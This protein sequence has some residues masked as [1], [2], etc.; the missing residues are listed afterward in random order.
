MP[1]KVSYKLKLTDVASRR[2]LRK[3]TS[4]EKN[5][6]KDEIGEL[7]LDLV[8]EKTSKQVSSVSGRAW[9]PLDPK[10]RYFKEK[11]KV[12]PSV[13]NLELTGAMLDSLET[14]NYRDGVEI[15][16]FGGGSD[17]NVLKAD[18]HNKFSAKARGTNLPKRQFIPLKNQSFSKD[19]M[20]DLKQAAA[21]YIEETTD[22]D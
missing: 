20:K 5:E 16:I 2:E 22:E 21:S 12:A 3:L 11:S 9:K 4:S 15:G 8:L 10:S 17:I 6:L 13:A 14:V 19:I 18:N 7:L 1:S